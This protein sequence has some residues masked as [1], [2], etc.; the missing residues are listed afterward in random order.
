M[1]FEAHFSTG[2]AI[3]LTLGSLLF[4]VA[5]LWLLGLFGEVPTGSRRVPDWAIPIL[6]WL[7]VVMF[8]PLAVWHLS[9]AFG[10]ELAVRIDQL[11]MLLTDYS[12]QPIGWDDVVAIR[13][14]NMMGNNILLFE[15]RPAR[16]EGFGWGRRL[17]AG[18]SR[19]MYGLGYSLSVNNTDRSH[20][21]LLAAI[22]HFAPPRL[23]G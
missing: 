21:E 8:G 15:V 4:V 16:A 6:G 13:T 22:E 7:C 5:G 3:L 2:R 19:T 12:D 14:E 18:S 20:R 17:M 1:P 10:G 23:L 9:R 11:G